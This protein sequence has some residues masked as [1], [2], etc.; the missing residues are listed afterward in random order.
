MSRLGKIAVVI[1]LVSA[2][3]PI[4]RAF[5]HVSLK[6]TNEVPPETKILAAVF[7]YQME[8]CYQQLSRRTYF[9]A[10]KRS[11]PSDDVMAEFKSYGSRVRKYS[12]RREFYKL[13]GDFGILLGIADVKLK[14]TR[15][16]S[17]E[18]SCG[19][20]ALDTS[21]YVYHLKRT[22]GNWIVRRLRRI[23]FS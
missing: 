6:E 21:S 16:A 9:L 1:S 20:G 13:S 14:S 10:Y 18:G 12:E 2:S 5:T 8:R 19:R 11:D 7:R 17:V 22:K 3:F 23:G 15:E 4:G